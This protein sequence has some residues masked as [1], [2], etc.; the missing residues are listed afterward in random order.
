MFKVAK[1][2]SSA[3]DFLSPAEDSP[4]LSKAAS[5]S[6]VGLS[7][8]EKIPLICVAASAAPVPVLD[9]AANAAATSLNSTFIALAI[10]RV[11]PID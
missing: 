1:R 9:S 8:E 4:K 6:V 3:N 10:G 2:P 7:N 11:L 5:A